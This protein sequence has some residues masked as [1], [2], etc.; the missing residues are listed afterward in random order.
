MGT[1]GLFPV[2]YG[3]PMTLPD[4]IS[5]LWATGKWPSY[6]HFAYI[7]P[8]IPTVTINKCLHLRNIFTTFPPLDN[9]KKHNI[10]S[11]LETKRSHSEGIKLC[12]T[13]T[14]YVCFKLIYSHLKNFPLVFIVITIY[15]N[16]LMAIFSIHFLCKFPNL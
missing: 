15:P 4:L 11:E 8:M 5:P 14:Y 3:A 16:S 13:L 1:L 6:L 9:I 12:S 2:R 7:L 10:V